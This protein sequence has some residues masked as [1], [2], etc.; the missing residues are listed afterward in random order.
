MDNGDTASGDGYKSRGR[1]IIR[2]LLEDTI[3]HSLQKA[4]TQACEQLLNI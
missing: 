4:L 3:T 1:G 2:N